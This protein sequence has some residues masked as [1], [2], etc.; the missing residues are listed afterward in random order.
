MPEQPFSGSA[1]RTEEKGGGEGLW[2]PRIATQL[3]EVLRIWRGAANFANE[4]ANLCYWRNHPR[5]SYR[6]SPHN[7]HP[8]VLVAV[9]G[10]AV[11]S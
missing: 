11:A 6:I 4:F 9:G 8:V 5:I 7:H 3:E 10:A 2:P 1:S